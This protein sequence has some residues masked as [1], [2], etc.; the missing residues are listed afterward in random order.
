MKFKM[1]KSALVSIGLMISSFANAGLI[2][3]TSGNEI[4]M[5]VMNESY[6]LTSNQSQDILY[7]AFL[8]VFLAGGGSVF[9]SARISGSANYSLNGGPAI[10]LSWWP[11]W[12]YRPGFQSPWTPEDVSFLFTLPTNT[13]SIGD[14]ITINGT[15]TMNSLLDSNIKVPDVTGSVQTVIGG[16]SVL[17]S[18]VRSTTFGA[19]AQVPEPSTLAIFT[20]AMMGFASRRFNK[21][22]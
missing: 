4:T 18:D 13:L 17:Y 12:Q 20:L 14:T 2:F 19:A 5:A 1:I 21:Q 7:V 3:S 16:H 6:T 15:L 10:A 22:S 11:G 9:D 8:D